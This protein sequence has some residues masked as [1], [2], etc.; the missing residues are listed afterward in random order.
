MIKNTISQS[1]MLFIPFVK[2]GTPVGPSSKGF[3]S[4]GLISNGPGMPAWLPN[5]PSGPLLGKSDDG[6][7]SLTKIRYCCFRTEY[8]FDLIS[9]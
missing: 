2:S 7:S 6:G 8:D 1:M 5:P 3:M 4:S 9:L